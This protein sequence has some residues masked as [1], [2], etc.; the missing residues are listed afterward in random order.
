MKNKITKTQIWIFVLT[1]IYVILFS[2][3]FFAT[4]N[5]EFIIYIF[6]LAFFVA[7]ISILHKKFYFPTWVLIGTSIWGLMHMAGGSVYINGTRLYDLIL[8]PLVNKY[9][10]LRYDQFVHLYCYVFVTLIVFYIFTYYLKKD[11]NKLIISVF[12]VFIGM[13]IGA[14]N[15]IIEFSAVLLLGNTGVGDYYNTAFDLVFNAIGAIIAVIIFNLR[16]KK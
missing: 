12:V 7:L 14:L 6:V 13:G 3:Y 1:I 8:I 16:R 2:I 5:N 10:I 11:Y 4:K 15:E 9:S